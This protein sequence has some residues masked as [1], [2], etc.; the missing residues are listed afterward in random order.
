MSFGSGPEIESAGCAGKPNGTPCPA[1][2]HGICINGECHLPLADQVADPDIADGT[3]TSDGGVFWNG[4]PHYKAL[5][6]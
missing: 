1:P 5:D 4:I 2:F 6:A 3:A